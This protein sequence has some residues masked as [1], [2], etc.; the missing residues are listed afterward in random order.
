VVKK[1]SLSEGDIGLKRSLGL[2][3]ITLYGL[4]NILGAGIYVLIGEVVAAAGMAAPLAFVLAAIVAALSAFTYGEL[5]ARF[6]VSAGEAVYVHQ[7]FGLRGLSIAVGLMI[8]AAGMVSS[9][10]LARGFAGYFL[11]LVELPEALVIVCLV[12]ALGL[13]AAWGIKSSVRI[14]ATLT[15]IEAGGLV[16]IVIVAGGNLDTVPESL[17]R[18]FLLE[19][20]A[21]FTGVLLGAFLAFFAFI[22]FEDMVNVAEEVENPARNLPLGILIALGVS[23][24][25][26][27]LVVLAALTSVPVEKLAGSKAPLALVYQHVTGGS[28][29]VISSIGL[30]AVVNGALV[31]VIM[32]ARIFY[33]MSVK[34]WLPR[35]LGSVNP[36]TRTPMTATVV[37]V[38]IVAGLALWFPLVNLASATSLLVLTVFG[39]VNLTLVVLKRRQPRAAGVMPCPMWVPMAGAGASFGLLVAQLLH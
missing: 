28:P 10:T 17:P 38:V 26:Y 7:A 2:T 4:G 32:A 21:A 25:I 15:I 11:V 27:L 33:G 1:K 8:A 13:I 9:A 24:I 5:A 3:L 37:V 36:R 18:M 34:G 39:I 12:A 20:N 14:A 23:T 35:W 16:M 29:V 31:Q 19:G 22:G 6:P 30:L